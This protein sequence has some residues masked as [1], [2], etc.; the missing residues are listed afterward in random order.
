M[1]TRSLRPG[2][3]SFGLIAL[4]PLGVVRPR[5]RLDLPYD[6]VVPCWMMPLAMG[7]SAF[8]YS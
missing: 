7:E 4:L 5:Y 8:V 3:L 6:R 1:R 2:W